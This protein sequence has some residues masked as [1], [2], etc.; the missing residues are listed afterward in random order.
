MDLRETDPAPPPGVT[1]TR[2]AFVLLVAAILLRFA[3][4]DRHDLWVDEA[5]SVEEALAPSVIDIVRVNPS[6]LPLY[7][8]IL[9]AW[10]RVDMSL[11]W[12]RSLS[13]CFG[14]LALLLLRRSVRRHFSE[15]LSIRVLLFAG[16]SAFAIYYSQEVR[17][18]AL[19]LLL[20]CVAIDAVWDLAAARGP[21]TG[22][23]ARYVAAGVAM[24]YN[25]VFA[26]PFLG[27]S[28]LGGLCYPAIRAR[29]GGWVL[30]HATAVACFL[31]WVPAFLESTL[32][33]P[34]ID[35]IGRHVDWLR[36][37]AAPFVV[38]SLGKTLI[39]HPGTPT[40]LLDAFLFGSGLLG[41]AVLGVA[42]VRRI[43]HMGR[44]PDLAYGAIVL[45]LPLIFGILATRC[46]LRIYNFARVKYLIFAWP[47]LPL[48]FSLGW[49]ELE[50]RLSPRVT[51]AAV[52]ALLAANALA[53]GHYFVDDDYLRAPRYRQA[54]SDLARIAGPDEPVA[55]HGTWIFQPVQMTQR[56]LGQG[57][58]PVYLIENPVPL[59]F[60][61]GRTPVWDRAVAR[62]ADLPLPAGGSAW[63]A[64]Y[65]EWRARGLRDRPAF[66]DK[67][68]GWESE[69]FVQEDGVRALGIRIDRM[70]RR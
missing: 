11:P 37:A 52:A 51:R 42:G 20:A 41:A 14:A 45:L 12:L 7:P 69:G 53:L 67:E 34:E 30:L 32:A 36:D 29:L 58:S 16:F 6:E 54:L 28:F 24:L 18:F 21:A 15:D 38:F 49:A 1:L 64:A 26:F 63:R 13:A 17:N 61:D 47:F 46:G 55:C 66:A 62:P 31:P 44:A 10:I 59:L 68:A 22:A 56:I 19:F 57:R 27:A 2:T 48:A 33:A 50:E 3:F 25:H 60:R 8:W 40:F 23:A 9:S 35:P 39:P 5:L 4:L 43:L 70:R 65:V